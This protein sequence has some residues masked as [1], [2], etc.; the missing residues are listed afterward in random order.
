MVKDFPLD[1]E[2][3]LFQ[4]AGYYR[5]K[6]PND[7]YPDSE[8]LRTGDIVTRSRFSRLEHAQAAVRDLNEWARVQGGRPP[9]EDKLKDIP[10]IDDL[11][12]KKKG[13]KDKPKE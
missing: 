13:K 8:V 5:I 3:V 10:N 7:K 11:F 1:P 4:V 9:N 12:P 2:K 6:L